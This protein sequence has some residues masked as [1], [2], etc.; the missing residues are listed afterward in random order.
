MADI[1]YK[2][3]NTPYGG[4][5]SITLSLDQMPDFFPIDEDLKQN[6]YVSDTGKLWQ[7]TWYR[8]RTYA[9]QFRNVGTNLAATM[10]SF[11]REGYKINWHDDVDNAGGT[12]TFTTSGGFA[13]RAI[14]P[15]IVDFAFTL[16][17]E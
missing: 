9:L 15:D 2:F 16:R 3:D 8:K 13:Y 17:E 1:K 4:N 11:V 7:Y 10:G 14:S 5:Q 6:R 12:G